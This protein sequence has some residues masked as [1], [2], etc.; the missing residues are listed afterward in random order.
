MKRDPYILFLSPLL[1]EIFAFLDIHVT[2]YIFFYFTHL[3]FLKNR[4]MLEQ[5][6]RIIC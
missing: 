1:K 4:G 5:H 6:S 3:K 2:R